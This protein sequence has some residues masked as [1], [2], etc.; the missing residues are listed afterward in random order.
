MLPAVRAVSSETRRPGD[1]GEVEH[2]VVAAAGAGRAVGGGEQGGGL[3]LGEPG[4]QGLVG[5][6][7]GDG[8]DTGDEGGVLGVA[9]CRVA[10]S[11]V[12]RGEPGVAGADA[13]AAVFFQVAEEGRDGGGVEVGEVEAGRRLPGAPGG[14]GEQHAPGVA[15]GGDGV[16]AGAALGSEPLGEERFQGGGQGGHRAAPGSRRAA[17]RASSSGVP[18]RYQ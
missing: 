2:G 4:D 15:V 6:L 11:G 14:E 12:D 16:A 17:A 9:Q 18:V 5:A 8:Q 1:D 13:V 10:E 7:G 3:V